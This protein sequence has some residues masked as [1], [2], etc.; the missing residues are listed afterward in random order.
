MCSHSFSGHLRGLKVEPRGL[1]PCRRIVYWLSHQSS[2][3]LPQRYWECEVSQQRAL[4][5]AVPCFRGC[6]GS[7]TAWESQTNWW[8]QTLRAALPPLPKPGLHAA[9]RTVRSQLMRTHILPS[10]VGDCASR[11]CYHSH[12]AVFSVFS[13]EPNL[14]DDCQDPVANIWRA[15][16]AG[17]WSGRNMTLKMLPSAVV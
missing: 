8:A 13:V 4:C 12:Q 6:P 7:R 17:V 2:L 15:A 14:G 1:P 11:K 3:T 5:Q 9:L 16:R 10:G